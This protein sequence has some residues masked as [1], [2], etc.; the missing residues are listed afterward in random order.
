MILNFAYSTDKTVASFILPVDH[1]W[2]QHGA[3]TDTCGVVFIEDYGK[4]DWNM[5]AL[6][7]CIILVASPRVTCECMK[8]KLHI[9]SHHLIVGQCARIGLYV[10]DLKLVK[11]SSCNICGEDQDPAFICCKSTF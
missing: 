10:I 7:Y 4:G 8:P 1:V 5:R 11:Q 3:S 9:K 6:F 2:S